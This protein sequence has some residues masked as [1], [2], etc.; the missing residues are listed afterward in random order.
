MRALRLLAIVGLAA[1]SI[2]VTVAAEDD[3][4][5]D[6]FSFAVFGDSRPGNREYSPVLQAMM[7]EI[8]GLDVRFVIGTGDYIEGSSNQNTVRRQWEG[9][10]TALEP[11]Q[12]QRTIPLALAPGNHDIMG[13]RRNAEIFL[14]HFKRLYFSF[15]YESCHFIILNTE[16]LGH[17]GR[18]TGRQLQWLKQDLADHNDAKFTFV[19]LHRPLFPVDGH[20]GSS[21][22]QFPAERDALHVLFRQHGVDAVFA[23]HEH[24]YNYQERDG[25]YYFITGGAGA[26]LYTVPERGGFYHYLLVSVGRDSYTVEVRRISF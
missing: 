7:T 24:L 5:A 25:I 18:I 3:S 8:G 1:W 16:T 26:P 2:G 12:A 13:V 4:V 15:E 22:D 14:E 20:V 9:F 10:F 17:E 19:A 6:P 23:G 21:L 11:L